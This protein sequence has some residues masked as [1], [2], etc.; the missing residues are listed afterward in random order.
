MHRLITI[1][2]SH[3]CEKARW[4]LDLSGVP[5]VEE[6]HLPFF[7]RRA[8]RPLGSTTVPLLVTPSR[9]LTDSSDILAFADAARPLYPTDP[10]ARRDGLALED[11]LDERFGPQT[12]RLAYFHL[13]GAREAFDALLATAPVP[14]WER[15]A[16]RLTR[17]LATAVLRRALGVD[18]ARA[19]RSEARVR[20]T[21]AAL[22]ARLARHPYLCGDAFSAADLTFASLA[23]PLLLPD[24]HPLGWPPR[25]TLPPAF[26]ALVASLRATRA[27][28]HALRCYASHRSPS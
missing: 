16:M 4:A 12:R 5:Y 22:D 26:L 21:F 1:P 3:Y 28:A 13:L 25:D 9:V 20:E 15:R 14:S 7:S 6:G 19:A 23:G 27:G 8:T 24:G 18:A 2:F 11:E 10:D 17:P